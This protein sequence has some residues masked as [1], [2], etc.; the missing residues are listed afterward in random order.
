MDD[1]ITMIVDGG[2]SGSDGCA[3]RWGLVWGYRLSSH[4]L[5]CKAH[6]Y[7]NGSRQKIRNKSSR[8]KPKCIPVVPVYRSNSPNI[9][10]ETIDT[11]HGSNRYNP[12]WFCLQQELTSKS[13]DFHLCYL[14]ILHRTF[15]QSLQSTVFS[16]LVPS[17]Q[18][19]YHSHQWSWWYTILKQSIDDTIWYWFSIAQRCEECKWLLCRRLRIVIWR[20]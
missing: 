1:I 19:L 14:C 15:G 10:K 20:R 5:G 17:S 18:T 16:D 6:T 9:S 2:R 7:S 4:S 12:T 13:D 3:M 11:P 8:I